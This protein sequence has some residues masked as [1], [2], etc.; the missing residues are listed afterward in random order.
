MVP[1]IEPRLAKH[2]RR[3]FRGY[4]VATVAFYGPD[5]ST[6]TKVA[7]GIVPR[8]GAEVSLL[9]RWH[10][11]EVDVRIDPAIGRQVEALI[12]KHAVRSVVLSPGII[13][14]PHEEGVDYKGEYC[15]LC[16]Y[17][18]GRDR[19]AGTALHPAPKHAP[20]DMVVGVAWYS[21]DE[22]PRVRAIAADPETLEA[23]YDDWLKVFTEGKA[24]LRQAG[25][26]AED[27]PVLAGD[28]QA[29]CAAEGRPIDGDAR[30]GYAAEQLRRKHQGSD[31][32]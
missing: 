3:G 24:A 7:V 6:A 19:W 8:E 21:R 20:D 16:P 18:Q 1:R 32:R 23:S 29:W 22:W 30:A 14:C 11:S 27:V 5:A 10:S 4:P 13:G 15:P 2:A 17:W 9:E 28:L 31:S 12:K 25:I 26:V